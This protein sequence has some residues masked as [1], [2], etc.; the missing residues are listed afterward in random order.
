MNKKKLKKKIRTENN[1]LDTGI[2]YLNHEFNC[3][4][5]EFK[6][7]SKDKNKNKRVKYC[8]KARRELKKYKKESP[9]WCPL[10][11]N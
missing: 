9:N 3:D 4:D 2:V 8:H 7:W 10:K 6:D 1:F 11:K 5:C